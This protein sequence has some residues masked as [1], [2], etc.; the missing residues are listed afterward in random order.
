MYYFNIYIA[1]IARLTEH[2]RHIWSFINSVA[3]N[4]CAL[5]GTD[6]K[7][8]GFHAANFFF[9]FNH[10]EKEYQSIPI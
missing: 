10:S 7:V 8:H 2:P 3:R 5:D 1:G 6:V 9:I 4:R